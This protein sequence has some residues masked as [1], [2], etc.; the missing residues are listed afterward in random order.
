M[1]S[2]YQFMSQSES[3][4]F[5]HRYSGFAELLRKQAAQEGHDSISFNLPGQGAIRYF[6]DHLQHSNI[7][8]I[9]LTGS[10]MTIRDIAALCHVLEKSDNISQLK[11]GYTHFNTER[12]N[13]VAKALGDKQGLVEL[14]IPDADLSGSG[15][16]IAD[17]IRKNP[18][19]KMLALNQC[20]FNDADAVEVASALSQC[21]ELQLLQY[22]GNPRTAVTIAESVIPHKHLIQMDFSTSN[23]EIAPQIERLI[24][25]HPSPNLTMVAGENSGDLSAFLGENNQAILRCYESLKEEDAPLTLSRKA[26]L[27]YSLE[28]HRPF[29][30]QFKGDEIWKK[31]EQHA[32]QP[33]GIGSHSPKEL[34]WWFAA[35]PEKQGF[36][37]IDNPRLFADAA[38]ARAFLAEAPLTRAVLRQQSAA[39]S[40]ILQPVLMHL[41]AREVINSLNRRNL[42]L[43]VAE[44]L[45]DQGQ[46]NALFD[47]LRQ[48]HQ[49]NALFTHSNLA[50]ITP[51][52]ARLL[53]ASLP[54]YQKVPEQAMRQMTRPVSMGRGR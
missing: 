37:P 48:S 42:S 30:M 26:A 45:D 49:V 4:D 34:E 51:E 43:Q 27:Q 53:S 14:D 44:L 50:N 25:Q 54:G 20:S 8:Q 3:R 32:A 21:R 18:G 24:F 19:L 2:R 5:E 1:E 52:N 23:A 29:F 15:A 7:S 10:T 40:H 12:L 13:M 35:Q 9:S 16:V 38:E 6:A 46:P 22:Q 31:Y 36:A 11:V 33:P 41:P 28:L 39:G 17:L 47:L